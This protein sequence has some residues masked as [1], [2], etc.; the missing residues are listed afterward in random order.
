MP[1][2]PHQYARLFARQ[3]NTNDE[4]QRDA[5]AAYAARTKR[6]QEAWRHD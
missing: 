3:S 6:L 5:Q 1:P 2:T 4:L